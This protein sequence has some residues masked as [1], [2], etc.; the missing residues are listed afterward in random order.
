V[1]IQTGEPGVQALAAWDED[2][3]MLHALVWNFAVTAPPARRVDL[4]LRNLKGKTWM[5]RRFLLDA[6]T[7]SNQENDRM[8]MARAEQ[9][10]G[11]EFQDGF[12]LPPY[13]VA[14]VALRRLK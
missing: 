13:G 9:F 6:E 7:A 2:Q 12:T 3:Q 10:E 1:E 11:G 8:R 14:L 5:F 4:A